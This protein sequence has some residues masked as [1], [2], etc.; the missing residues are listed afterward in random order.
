MIAGGLT[1]LEVLDADHAR[2]RED[3]ERT[4]KA[5]LDDSIYVSVSWWLRAHNIGGHVLLAIDEPVQE[6]PDES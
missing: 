6:P 3:A 2:T 5:W 1:L 4:G